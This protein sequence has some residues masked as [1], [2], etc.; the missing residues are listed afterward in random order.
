MPELESSGRPASVAIAFDD[1]RFLGR[2]LAFKLACDIGIV[3]ID[4]HCNF[5]FEPL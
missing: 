3:A 5:A 1:L 4:R 2:D